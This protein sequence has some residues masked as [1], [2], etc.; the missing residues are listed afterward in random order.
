MTEANSANST[1]GGNNPQRR[2]G[3]FACDACRSRRTR[4]DGQRPKCSFC[5]ERRRDCVYPEPPEVPPTRLELELSTIGERLDQILG[6]LGPQYSQRTFYVPIQSGQQQQ[7]VNFLRGQDVCPEFPFMII[8]CRSV[9]ELLGLDHNLSSDLV[10]LERAEKTWPPPSEWLSPLVIESQHALA[11]LVAFSEQINSWYP[12]LHAN[13]TGQFL[14]AV[15]NSFPNSPESCLSLLILAV[16]SLVSYESISQ[17]I[18]DRPDAPYIAA[19]SSMISTVLLDDSVISAQCLLL[20]SIY[21]NCLIKPCHAHDFVVIAS[22]K[23]QTI[24]KSG[25]YENDPEELS[26]IRTCYW[27]ALLIES[28]LNVQL[29]LVESDIW[30]MCPKIPLP[31]ASN[32]WS[33][34]AASIS[35]LWPDHPVPDVDTGDESR[36]Y[37]TTEIMMRKMLQHCTLSVSKDINNNFVYAP[38]VAAELERQLDEWHSY[39]PESLS[40]SVDGKPAKSPRTS[41]QTDFLS[42]QFYAYRASIYWPAA[43]QAIDSNETNG[44]LLIHCQRFFDSYVHFIASTTQAV[45]T[46]RPNAWTLY[47]RSLKNILSEQRSAARNIQLSAY[48]CTDDWRCFRREPIPGEA[49][50]HSSPKCSEPFLAFKFGVS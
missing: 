24:I 32:T 10:K 30:S 23:I 41:A 6:L 48:G 42:A 21:F 35:N 8:Q 3:N 46:C 2:R 38:I 14:H 31:V 43:Y 13:I 26:M 7:Q 5:K 12:I 20:L 18:H 17:A 33:F 44:N 9:M 50:E 47:A 34:N 19:A 1:S 45:R 11:T 39:L 36:L 49:G 25:L 4:C 27:V 22:F 29:D 15:V 40:F 16:G 37:F 28:E